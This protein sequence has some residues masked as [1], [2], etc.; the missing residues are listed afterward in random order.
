MDFLFNDC[1]IDEIFQS[2]AI[3][4]YIKHAIFKIVQM[5]QYLVCNI[6]VILQFGVVHCIFPQ[7]LELSFTLLIYLNKYYEH[8]YAHK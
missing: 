6:G 5:R 8:S 1:T 3:Y 2:Y 4:I 7:N